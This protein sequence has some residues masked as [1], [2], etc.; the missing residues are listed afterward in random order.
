VGPVPAVLLVVAADEGWMPQ[1]D[2]HV[3]ALDALGVGH[4][5][6]AVTRSDRT[7]P[8]RVAEQHHDDAG[9]GGHRGR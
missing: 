8:E 5:V 1:T 4:A 6:V 3:M 9:G 7:D 2:E